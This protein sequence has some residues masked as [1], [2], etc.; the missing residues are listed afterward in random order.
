MVAAVEKKKDDEKAA[1]LTKAR[2]ALQKYHN[3]V[4]SLSDKDWGDV[5]RW[6]IQAA[7]VTVVLKDYKKKDVIVAKLE[8]LPS[9][10]TSYI[11]PFDE[12]AEESETTQEVAV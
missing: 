4:N 5:L 6:V 7:G 2:A 1:K 12:P 11:P 8:S 3:N 10:W 9:P